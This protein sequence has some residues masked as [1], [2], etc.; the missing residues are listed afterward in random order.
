M[1]YFEN[2]EGK[3]MLGN[4]SILK[5]SKKR[6]EKGQDKY[7]SCLLCIKV[8]HGNQKVDVGKLYIEKCY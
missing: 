1:G 7:L 2:Q 3:K 4:Q 6:W 8:S 5:P